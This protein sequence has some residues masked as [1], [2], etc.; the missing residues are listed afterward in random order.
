MFI[1]IPAE[2]A[3][4][5]V[6][7]V[8]ELAPV[9]NNIAAYVPRRRKRKLHI[10]LFGYSRNLNGI[11]LPRAIGFTAALY[12][13][14]LPPELLGL[15]ALDKSD[16]AFLRENYVNFDRDLQAALRFANPHE[17]RYFPRVLQRAV[18]RLG[19]DVDCDLAHADLNA[20]ILDSIKLNQYSTLDGLIL[21]AA[22]LRRFLG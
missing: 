13:I 10:G 17:H 5:N 3:S 12:S 1:V 14:G 20:K 11:H 15:D 4:A 8:A 7:S 16:I 9:I 2:S 6:T 21:R 19:L 22:F 18:D